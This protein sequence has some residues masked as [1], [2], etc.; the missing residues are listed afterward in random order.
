MKMWIVIIEYSF[1]NEILIYDQL[2]NA[3]E[4]YQKEKNSGQLVY[5]T[6]VIKSNM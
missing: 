3:E 4:R 1:D 5:L 2:E 6:K